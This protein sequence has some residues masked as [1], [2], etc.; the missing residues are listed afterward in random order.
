MDGRAQGWTQT[1]GTRSETADDDNR[2]RFDWPVP[3]GQPARE[4]WYGLVTHPS[5]PLALWVRYTLVSITAGHR[6]ARIWGALTDGAGDRSCFGTRSRRLDDL[7]LS[8]APFELIIDGAGTLAS[9]GATGSVETDAGRL[10]WDLEHEPDPVTFTP[11][12]SRRLT[13]LASRL[14]GTG[15]HRSCNQSIRT[16]GTVTLDG[17][18]IRFEDAPA[19]QGHTVGR[20]SPDRWRWVHCNT[21]GGD[22]AVEAL[23]V[24]GRLSICLRTPDGVHRL[25]RLHH[26]V[27]P[28]ANETVA[29]EPGRWRFRGAG[30]GARVEC[31]VRA[32]PAHW[33]RVSYL[34]PDGSRRYN[35]HCSLS[36]VELRVNTSVTDGWAEM[37]SD[38]GRAE[39]VAAE[40]PVAGTYRPER[41]TVDA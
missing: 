15:R 20:S 26:L 24:S 22:W 8:A 13:T 35:A 16:A 6:E 14:L 38:R 10:T 34:C 39:W 17:E 25:N 3:A 31:T 11:L 12:R 4:V 30:D 19:H 27:G 1:A 7:S 5:R 23:A 41:W 32:E 21:F 29:A 28:W 33:Q 9:D 37:N 40:P 18:R 36:R 2:P